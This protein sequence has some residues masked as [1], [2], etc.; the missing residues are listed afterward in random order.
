MRRRMETK[1]CCQ[2]RSAS[3]HRDHR[4]NRKNSLTTPS[5]CIRPLAHFYQLISL[6]T[7][8]PPIPR[9]CSRA[10]SRNP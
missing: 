8:T 5:C 7:Y 9:R 3:C 10:L 4:G 6:L 2:T 1:T